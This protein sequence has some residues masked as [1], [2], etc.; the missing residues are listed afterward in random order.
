MALPITMATLYEQP[1]G[2]YSATSTGANG[3]QTVQ[4]P[5]TDLVAVDDLDANGAET[6]SDLQAYAQ[7]IYHELIEAPGSNL[8]DPAGG[9]G[10]GGLM[11]GASSDVVR[12][13][14]TIDPRL[15]Q[16]PRCAKS[17]TTLV[18]DSLGA[19]V[20]ASIDIE[21]VGSLLPLNFS[22]SKSAGLQGGNV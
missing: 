14:S 22:W 7:D 16:D 18:T 11:S 19:P 1:D 17:E 2:T 6:T 13:V 15:S 20:S 5:V 21:P 12:A 4:V 3:E 8:A 9:I 10:I